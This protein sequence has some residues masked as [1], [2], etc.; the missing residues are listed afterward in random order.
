M[1]LKF[2]GTRGS[3]PIANPES[4]RFGGNTTCVQI[5]SDCLP[6]GSILVIDA[7]SGFVPLTNDALQTG[8]VNDVT[9][10]FTHYHHDHTQGLLL[11]NFMFMKGM[12]L[13]LCGPVEM[14]IGPKEMLQ[15]IMQPPYFPV[16]SKEV[17]SHIAYKGF[18]FPKTLVV[19]VHPQGGYKVMDVDEYER[20]VKTDQHLPIG[21]G[22]YPVAEC[23][24]IMMY[25]ANHPEQTI[26]YRFDE[27]PTGKVFVFMTDHQNEDGISLMMRAHIRSANL[28]VMD[29]QY[30][31]HMY[32]ASTAGFGHGTPD[33]CVKV[34]EEMK[35]GR[36]GLTHHNPGSTDKDI[37]AILEEG[38]RKSNG[39]GIEIFACAD[40]QEVEV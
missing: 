24:V 15:H 32:D 23:L 13:V 40:Y 12:K 6:K 20:L 19:L 18:E 38:E 33:Y 27:K 26:S 36:L 31:R 37:E 8:G 11:S 2:Y 29:S 17:A 10:L 34:A 14:G 28:I 4:V 9:V 1:K 39:S 35:V 30:S 22:K 21:K 3:I 25:K 5:M 7:G 16:H